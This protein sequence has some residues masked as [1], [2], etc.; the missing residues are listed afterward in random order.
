[1]NEVEII[2]HYGH[3]G[4]ILRFKN[5]T[6]LYPVNRYQS[7]LMATNAH[8]EALA[9]SQRTGRP[10]EMMRALEV[11]CGG[12]PAAIVLKDAGVGF[13]EASDIN[14]L[15]LELCRQNARANDLEI[16]SIALRDMLGKSREDTEKLDLIVCNPP[17]G[18]SCMHRV[19]PTEDYLKAVNGGTEGVDFV[20]PLIGAVKE[21][22][23][24]DGLLIF[25][26]TSTMHVVRVV[27]TLDRHF[28]DHWR[29]TYHTP[30]AQPMVPVSS[31]RAISL[32]SL[33]KE[34]E[35]LIWDNDDGWLWRLTWI[36]VA[37]HGVS[38]EP[39]RGGRLW[40]EPYGY[41]ISLAYSQAVKRFERRWRLSGR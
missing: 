23:R 18:R 32:K 8:T 4:R 25:V 33:A 35:A 41:E 1:M 3:D 29:N 14:P 27:E 31:H 10:L 20:L 28:P 6:G 39:T 16:D 19:A 15:A 13:V 37:K 38:G 22:L 30:V 12:G 36:V 34:G 26:L 21:H 7:L 17:C 24:P 11:C 5:Q 40:F 2:R 9:H